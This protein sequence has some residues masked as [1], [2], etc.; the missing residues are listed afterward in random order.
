MREVASFCHRGGD[1]DHR[2]TP[3]PTGAQGI[4]GHQRVYRRRPASYL[5]EYPVSGQYPLA[6]G[7]WSLRLRGR[8]DGY[9]P[10]QGMVEEIKTCRVD[11]A[12]IPEAVTRLHLAQGRLYAAMIAQAEDL[13][14]L[15]VRL[16][17]LQLDTDREHSVCQ[18][19][20]RL[21][22][23]EFLHQTLQH[24]GGWLSRLAALRERRD[25]SVAQLA[26]PHPQFREGQRNIAE[27]VYKC[28]DQ[29]G[30]LLIE[31]PTGIGKTAAVMFPALKALARDKHD[32]LV[33]AT[34]KTVGRRAAEQTLDR[35]RAA[36][37]SGSS[38]SLSA[39]DKVCLAP[40]KAC[41]GDDCPYARN[42]YDKLPAAMD[43]AITLPALPREQ[44][45]LLAREH[46]VCPYQLAW[47]LLPWVDCIIAD[48]HYLYALT[49]NLVMRFAEAGRR[50][51]VLLDEA[52]NLPGR[53]RGMYS[54][55]LAKA[56][57]MEATKA[58]PGPLAA[59]LRAI[60]RSLLELQREPWPEEGW[61]SRA[62][63]PPA[64]LLNLQN[65]VAAVGEQLALQPLLLQREPRV[66]DFYFG[67]LQFLRVAE[68]WGEHFRFEMSRDTGRQ[69][70][71]LKLNCLDPGPLLN[72]RQQALHAVVAFSATLSP[73]QWSRHGLGLLDTAVCHQA[74]SPFD[75]A[76]LKVALALDVD[77]RYARRCESLPAL[78]QLLI[79]WLAQVPGNCLLYFPSYQYL[80][81]C[82]HLV[83]SQPGEIPGRQLWV[84][85]RGQDDA[86]RD[87]LLQLLVSRRDLA[88]FCILGG[89]F[90]EGIDLPGDQLSSVVVVGVGLPQVNRDTETQ[91]R[92]FQARFGAGFAYAY[93]YPGMQK[94]AQA[95]GRVVRTPRDY[96]HALLVDCRYREP[97]YRRLLP[98]WWHYQGPGGDPDAG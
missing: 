22:L 80:Q 83:A 71:V 93:Q 23:D 68:Q 98:Q 56:Q 29:G 86:G 44:L 12:A 4:E 59:P 1:I 70:L 2:F 49:S 82:L 64:L 92:Y 41:H 7:G 57:L 39:R 27:L 19:Y 16:T 63:L 65:F 20:A 37:F 61:D 9:D 26:F 28:I 88:A 94:V 97:D 51:T 89:V 74:G 6:A 43:A 21:E 15:E 69:S 25:A 75:P 10:S 72:P 85:S 47:D 11:P 32:V 67:V 3:S 87:E 73:W 45:E 46:E 96:G 54:A 95:L 52:H 62:E 76:Q 8:A 60:N 17:W 38:L 90:G 14:A 30:Q 31:A 48:L 13:Q 55:A 81:D 24:F 35:F 53:A 34:A 77:T 66:L 40:G 42:Y 50:C 84:Q 58:A 79:D 36:G 91:R 18:H 33:F 78:A 5:T